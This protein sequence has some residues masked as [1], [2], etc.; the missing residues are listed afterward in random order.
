MSIA[1][2]PGLPVPVSLLPLVLPLAEYTVRCGFPSPADDFNCK[3]VDL[4]EQLVQHPQATFLVK[5]RGDS[6]KEA[7]IFD[8]D[9]LVVDRA[10]RAAQGHIVV[11]VLDGGEFTVK[12]LQRRAGHIRLVA[13]NPTY[14]DIVPREGQTLEVWGVVTASIKQ[15][16]R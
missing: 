10:I 4:T 11:A 2:L 12:Y 15:F 6:M 5:V 3:R 9:V 16:R 8:G 13:A 14:P 1:L 7:G